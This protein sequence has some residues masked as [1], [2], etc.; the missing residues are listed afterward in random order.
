MILNLRWEKEQHKIHKNRCPSAIVT[1]IVPANR[2]PTE[3]HCTQNKLRF[4]EHT[5]KPTLLNIIQFRKIKYLPK[6]KFER[7]TNNLKKKQ[8]KSDFHFLLWCSLC[9]KWT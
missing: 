5:R 2:R 6:R 1:G 7:K 4:I 9:N 8:E 3:Q